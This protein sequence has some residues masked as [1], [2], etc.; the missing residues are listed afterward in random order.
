MSCQED[1][2]QEIFVQIHEKLIEASSSVLESYLAAADEDDANQIL[3]LAKSKLRSGSITLSE[4]KDIQAKDALEKRALMG[5]SFTSPESQE[6]GPANQAHPQTLFGKKRGVLF[7]STRQEGDV[8]TLLAGTDTTPGASEAAQGVSSPMG[9]LMSSYLSSSP[10]SLP[11]MQKLLSDGRKIATKNLER[12]RSSRGAAADEFWEPADL[13]SPTLSAQLSA[14]GAEGELLL[15]LV[16][17]VS[18]LEEALNKITNPAPATSVDRRV[19]DGVESKVSAGETPV[20]RPLSVEEAGPTFMSRLSQQS[21][22]LLGP[23]RSFSLGSR[24]SSQQAL[25]L[26]EGGTTTPP[27]TPPAMYGG[28][29]QQSFIEEERDHLAED[30]G[31]P[32]PAAHHAIGVHLDEIQLLRM[33]L[34]RAEQENVQLRR[35]LESRVVAGAASTTVPDEPPSAGLDL[36]SLEEVCNGAGDGEV[37]L[38]GHLIQ[39]EGEPALPR[40][41]SSTSRSSSRAGL[42]EVQP[43]T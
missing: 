4:Y 36:P 10:V 3:R 32:S 31:P 13:L 39:S 28:P 23:Q 12:L 24:P 21:F 29:S 5:E 34:Q 6:A 15:R 7:V 2:T 19:S 37:A 1:S 14:P 33:E 17:K 35:L 20:A 43:P 40:N 38:Q 9:S 27:R 30:E 16:N 8:N 42:E 26:L 41:S 11:A 25:T 18:K 22:A